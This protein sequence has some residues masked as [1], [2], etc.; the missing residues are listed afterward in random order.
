MTLKNRKCRKYPISSKTNQS[1]TWHEL[2][3]RVW[4]GSIEGKI[5]FWG[6]SL[7]EHWTS[8]GGGETDLE[9][10]YGYV[11]QSCPPF[12]RPVGTRQIS[13]VPLMCPPFSTFRKIC[14]FGQNSVLKRQHFSIF[15]PKEVHA[16]P[17]RPLIFQEKP[18]P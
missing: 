1:R 4:E 11:P 2:C 6:D 12:F 9:R 3:L 7:K 15:A 10:A 5:H 14:V 18:T 13:N 16:R 8:I 17:P